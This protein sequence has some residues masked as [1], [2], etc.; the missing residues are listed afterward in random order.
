[1]PILGKVTATPIIVGC[2]EVD[3]HLAAAA[4]AHDVEQTTVDAG[5]R[6]LGLKGTNRGV[7]H[8]LKVDIG[9]TNCGVRN[10][11][12]GGIERHVCDRLVDHFHQVVGGDDK[13]ASGEVVEIIDVGGNSVV[14]GRAVIHGE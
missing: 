5:G 7:I 1:M 12:T 9:R 14:S 3:G 4:R 13:L 11:A 2:A 6:R 10:I 8:L